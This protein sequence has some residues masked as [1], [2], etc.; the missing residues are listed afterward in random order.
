VARWSCDI[1]ISCWS[2]PHP[3]A[4][5]PEPRQAFVSV[6]TGEEELWPSPRFTSFSTPLPLRQARGMRYSL[7][8]LV[9]LIDCQMLADGFQNCLY[10]SHNLLIRIPNNSISKLLKRFTTLCIVI[11]LLLMN[12]PID[13]NNQV[14]FKTT[15]INN[16]PIDCMLTTKL[17][18][19]NLSI[20]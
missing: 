18:I 6:A 5:F 19:A 11:Q 7:I 8:D 13:L 1:L 12:K 14:L 10:I 15:K 17:K 9:L 20:P 3:L 16:K 4:P 2:G